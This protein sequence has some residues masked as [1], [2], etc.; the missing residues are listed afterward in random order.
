MAQADWLGSNVG[1]LFCIHRV[2]H[3]NSCCDGR[4]DGWREF[5]STKTN[6]GNRKGLRPSMLVPVLNLIF[7]LLPITSSHSHAS[8]SDSTINLWRYINIH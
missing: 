4:M 8:A 2:N 6:A 7:L 3:V 1:V 5:I